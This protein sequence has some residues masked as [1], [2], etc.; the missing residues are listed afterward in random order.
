[1]WITRSLTNVVTPT[2]VA[3]G[4]FDGIHQGHRQVILPIIKSP[5]SELPANVYSTVVTFF[6]HPKVVL[7]GQPLSLLTPLDEKVAQLEAIGV[8]Q[9]VLLPFNEEFARLSPTEFVETI[10]LKELQAKCVSVGFD[11]CFGRQRSGNAED[12]CQLAAV[13]GIEVEIAP[14]KLLEGDRISSSAIRQA[15]QAGD[16]HRANY[17]LGRPYSL[18]GEVVQGQQLGRTIGFPTANLQLPPEKFLPSYGVYAVQAQVCPAT[19]Q[20][21]SPDSALLNGVMNLGMRPTVNGDRLTAEVHLFDWSGDLYSKVLSVN[22]HTFLRP[23]QKFA[24]LNELKAQISQD[25]DRAK[26]VLI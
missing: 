20:L 19:N 16:I 8:E 15:L 4:N 6:P 11:F 10:L 22:L 23:E 5:E 3:L 25:C 14:L 17:L 7:T 18:V 12:L 21:P 24:S 26:Q 9:L 2:A 13:S 1:V